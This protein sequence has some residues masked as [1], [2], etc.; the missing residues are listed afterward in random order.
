MNTELIK[1]VENYCKELLDKS[2]CK[3]LQFHNYQHTLDVVENAN[4]I[5]A[6][7]GIAEENRELLVIS[8]YFHDVGNMEANKAHEMLS[9]SIARSFL[10]SENYPEEK[11]KQIENIILATDIHRKPANLLEEIICDA[12]LG[13]LGK[14]SFLTKNRLLREEWENFLGMIFTDKEWL[15][16]NVR[17][18]DEHQF[19]TAIAR[20]IYGE[21][22][23]RN[24][25]NLREA[26]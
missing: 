10:E 11:I 7:S 13:H 5:A 18:L 9:C 8:A 23:S 3:S 20:K 4:L 2:R 16:L 17:F 15:Q 6:Q 12:D 22:K 25:I 14:K 1:K 21:Q 24:L 19:Y 26:L